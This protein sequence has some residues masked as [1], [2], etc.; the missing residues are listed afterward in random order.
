MFLSLKKSPMLATIKR[1]IAKFQHAQNK[2]EKITIIASVLF[3]LLD[4]GTD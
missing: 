2:D 3:D 4:D 1:G